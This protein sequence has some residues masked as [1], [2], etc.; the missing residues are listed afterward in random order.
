MPVLKY[1]L[2]LRQG[3][4]RGTITLERQSASLDEAMAWTKWLLSKPNNCL[5]LAPISV[6][7]HIFFPPLTQ[8]QLALT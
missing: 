5:T 3:W 1:A 6:P 4:N 2:A 7:A 8:K